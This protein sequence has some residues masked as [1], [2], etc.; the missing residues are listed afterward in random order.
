MSSART[1]NRPSSDVR[2]VS[3]LLTVVLALPA[4]AADRQRIAT[5]NVAATTLFTYLSCL[6]QKKAQKTVRP[7][8]C[9]SAGAVAGLGFY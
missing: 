3:L 2:L 7:R 9:L 8:V 5:I 4:R 6:A 1:R